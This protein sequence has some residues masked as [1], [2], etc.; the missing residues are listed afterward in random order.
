M[1]LYY[2]YCYLLP[3]AARLG[4]LVLQ[5]IIL[6]LLSSI[7]VSRFDLSQQYHN[8]HFLLFRLFNS[9]R[10][11]QLSLRYP[12]LLLVPKASNFLLPQAKNL[13][14][15]S[16]HSDPFLISSKSDTFSPLPAFIL[17]FGLEMMGN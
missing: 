14:L 3:R 2:Y 15:F 10:F 12:P 5:S 17:G 6:F 11:L 4:Y 8:N 16:L 1:L 9:K 7:C 13:P